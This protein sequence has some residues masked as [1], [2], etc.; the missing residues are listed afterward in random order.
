MPFIVFG[1]DVNKNREMMMQ[2]DN[3]KN[4]PPP[5]KGGS[6]VKASPFLTSSDFSFLQNPTYE[7]GYRHS[8]SI[9]MGK[10]SSDGLVGFGGNGFFTTDWTQKGV[11]LFVS[12]K[13]NNFSVSLTEIGE[14]RTK[15]FSYLKF[16]KSRKWTSGFG[17][18]YSLSKTQV[19]TT[20]P[21]QE[22]SAPS[23]MIFTA[24]DFY[25][26]KRLVFS[27][28][29]LLNQ[30]FGYFDKGDWKKDAA[31]NAFVGTGL[32][33]RLSKRFTL[34]GAYRGNINTNPKFGWMHNFLIGNRFNLK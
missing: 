32:G 25:L 12:K 16:I 28:E 23:I 24:R 20:L 34:V 9:G 19:T 13:N 29:I 10:T 6:K 31:F 11:S 3:F 14:S 2:T 30:S 27:P 1:Q 26:S 33:V 5:T 15:S 4:F 17:V 21:P 8:L 7:S 22:T 18:S